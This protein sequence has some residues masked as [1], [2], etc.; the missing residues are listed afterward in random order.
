MID[1]YK[2]IENNQRNQREMIVQNRPFS[3]KTNLKTAGKKSANFVCRKMFD[4]RE[5]G[6]SISYKT[7]PVQVVNIQGVVAIHH[8]LAMPLVVTSSNLKHCDGCDAKFAETQD[9][10]KKIQN[11]IFIHAVRRDL[12]ANPHKT[13][14]KAYETAMADE[15]G[16]IADEVVAMADEVEA[17]SKYKKNTFF[18]ILIQ[19]LRQN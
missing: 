17:F 1:E 4:G 13:I 9:P 19:N 16:S 18:F 15:A 5:C 10:E 2:L 8:E 6:A 3:L 11:R 7:T 12:T 14:Q